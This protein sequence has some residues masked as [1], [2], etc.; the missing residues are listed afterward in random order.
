[1]LKDLVEPHVLV[2]PV[3]PA[4]MG[5]TFLGRLDLLKVSPRSE[6][7][8]DVTMKKNMNQNNQVR[9]KYRACVNI[10]GWN[11]QSEKHIDARKANLASENCV[12][13]YF[14]SGFIGEIYIDLYG[15]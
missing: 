14:N 2:V 7:H 1:M 13:I 5:P 12:G 15:R 9:V 4:W 10:T 11:P 6:F 8:I 3:F